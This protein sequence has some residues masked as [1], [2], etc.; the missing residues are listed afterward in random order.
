[1]MGGREPPWMPRGPPERRMALL[2]DWI[3]DIARYLVRLAE[4]L[5]E[6][7]TD[8][9]GNWA[10]LPPRAVLQDCDKFFG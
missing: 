7:P 6:Q 8:H 2:R 10:I 9:V 4:G 3:S 5:Y 1:V